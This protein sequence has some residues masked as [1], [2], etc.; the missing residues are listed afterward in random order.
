MRVVHLLLSEAPRRTVVDEVADI[1]LVSENGVDHEVGPRTPVL[2]G[3]LRSIELPCDFNV[4]LSLHD[5][6]LEYPFDDRHFFVRTEP[7]P[8]AVRFQGLILA[9]P[10]PTF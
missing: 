9:L 5:E 2:I 10:E 8:H 1:V 6:L 3:D 4:G 7:K